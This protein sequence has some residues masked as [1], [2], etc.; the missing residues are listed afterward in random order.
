V[1]D[2]ELL[3]TAVRDLQE[4]VRELQ[5]QVARLQ[6]IEPVGGGPISTAAVSDTLTLAEVTAIFGDPAD[7]SA[8]M[9]K[10][11]DDGGAG[12]AF[13]LLVS[14]GANWWSFTGTKLT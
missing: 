5:R 13:Y 10:F 9:P 7:I 3:H 11:L 8:G 4:Q 6:R 1:S 2:T 14:D 12:T